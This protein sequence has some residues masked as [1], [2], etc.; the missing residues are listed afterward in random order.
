MYECGWDTDQLS[1]AK[2]VCVCGYVQIL[3]KQTEVAGA[4]IDEAT[5]LDRD[6]TRFSLYIAVL[7]QHEPVV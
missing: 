5:Q 6:P 4:H 2:G 7:N 1:P 3:L